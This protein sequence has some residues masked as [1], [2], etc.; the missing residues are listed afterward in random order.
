MRYITGQTQGPVPKGNKDR[1]IQL[2]FSGELFIWPSPQPMCCW[3]IA[4]FLELSEKCYC[5]FHHGLRRK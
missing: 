2:L 4:L 5:D 1:R 3:A